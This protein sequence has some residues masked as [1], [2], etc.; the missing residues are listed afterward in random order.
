MGTNYCWEL[1][2][3]TINEDEAKGLEIILSLVAAI[4]KKGVLCFRIWRGILRSN[5]FCCFLLDV[6]E[7]LIK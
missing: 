4:T 1:R 6:I 7:S 3:K 5:D 2:G